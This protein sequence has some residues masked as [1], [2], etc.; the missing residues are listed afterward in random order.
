MIAKYQLF[1]VEEIDELLRDSGGEKIVITET[2]INE[3]G[4]L[5]I[6]TQYFE[7]DLNPRVG[8]DSIHDDL[9]LDVRTENGFTIYHFPTSVDILEENERNTYLEI[10]FNALHFHSSLEKGRSCMNPIAHFRLIFSYINE[11]DR[12]D[13]Q[14]LLESYQR[15]IENVDYR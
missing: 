15:K 3:E 5:N 11:D 12:R 2:L 4:L 13:K 8:W 1:S 6:F 9:C 7:R 14:A 10:I